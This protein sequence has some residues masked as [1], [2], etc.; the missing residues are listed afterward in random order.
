MR[1][2][3]RD[4]ARQFARAIIMPNLDPPVVSIQQALAYRQRILQDLPEDIHQGAAF[5]PLMT[6]YLHES[7]TPAVIHE[8][9]QNSHIYAVKYYPA[10]ATTNSAD[11]ISDLRAIYPILEAMSE[12]DLPLLLHGEV[13]D[14]KVDIFD[15][16][17]VFI[18]RYLSPM[19]QDFPELR[20]VFEHISTKDA[21]DF[22]MAATDKLAATITPQ[23]LLLNRNALFLDGLRTHH[24]CLPVLKSERHRSAILSAATSGNKKFFLGTDSAPHAREDKESACGCAGIYSSHSAIELYAE[25]FEEGGCLDKLEGFA[26]HYG[27]DFYALP[28]NTD[29]II[30]EKKSWQVPNA[31]PFG[32]SELIPFHA[33]EWCTWKM[34]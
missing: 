12:H 9:S 14:P 28:R 29:T 5:R 15:R 18:D 33:G 32:D 19:I 3:L 26:S 8:A 23:H 13:T 24:Y 30:L 17:A 6:L 21:V 2:L 10:G 11:G 7:M 20:I 34:Q 16:E 1:G 27:A 25:A 4:T 31:I 22:V